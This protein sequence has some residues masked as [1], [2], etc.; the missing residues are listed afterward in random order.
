MTSL[1]RRFSANGSANDL[2]IFDLLGQLYA[3]DELRAALN[4]AIQMLEP[5]A[6]I[7]VFGHGQIVAQI[8]RTGRKPQ[9]PM[10]SPMSC[11]L[12]ITAPLTL[13]TS[14][15]GSAGEPIR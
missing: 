8:L 5:E 10:F 6:V 2:K 14:M 4:L 13:N 3:V 9:L 15:S 1:S 12:A 7:A 11:G